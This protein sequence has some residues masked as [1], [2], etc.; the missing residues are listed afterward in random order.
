MTATKTRSNKKSL[1]TE[2][3]EDV[4]GDGVET[5]SIPLKAKSVREPIEIDDTETLT[6]VDD[7]TPEDDSVSLFESEDDEL[8]DV[9]LDRDELNPFG[10]RWEE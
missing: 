4:H 10:D 9:S 3:H 7:K 6:V 8:G 5:E 2:H 1:A